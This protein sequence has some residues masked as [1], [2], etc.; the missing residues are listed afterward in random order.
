MLTRRMQLGLLGPA[1]L[2]GA[3][4]IAVLIL[5]TLLTAAAGWFGVNRMSFA[6][7]DMLFDSQSSGEA[8]YAAARQLF[9]SDREAIVL[10]HVGGN[11][12]E[13]ERARTAVSALADS[14]AEESAVGV[15]RWGF[16]RDAVSPKLIRTLPVDELREQAE[17]MAPV[18]LFLESETPAALL[19]AGM[20]EAMSRRLSGTGESA[21]AHADLEA[22]AAAF[23]GLLDTLTVRMKTPAERPVDFWSAMRDAAGEPRWNFL[24]SDGGGLLVMSVQLLEGV[25]DEAGVD[26]SLAELRRHVEAIRARFEGLEIGVTGYEASRREAEATLRGAV[27]RAAGGALAALVLLTGLAWRSVWRPAVV[28]LIP[29]AAVLWTLGGIG[30]LAGRV[31]LLALYGV[32]GAGL[33]ALFG[34]LL[35]VGAHARG[36]GRR[37]AVATAWPVVALGAVAVAVAVAGV[38]VWQ[39]VVG[40]GVHAGPSMPGLAGVREAGWAVI[41]G[42]CAAFLAVCV[43]GPALLAH[44]KPQKRPPGGA[45]GELALGLAAAAAR[46]PGRAW[47]AVGVL[48]MVLVCFAWRTPTALDLSGWM[49]ERSEARV[50]QLRAQV[51]GGEGGPVLW[52]VAEGWE[53]AVALTDRL[54]ALPEVGRVAGMGR[55]IPAEREAKAAVM[56]ELDERI[57]DAARAVAGLD[58]D[59]TS[60]TLAGQAPG[61]ELIEQV[62]FVR[63]ALMLIPGEA[64]TPTHR[65][66]TGM[67][68]SADRL[69]ADAD[70]LDPA[71]RDARLTA[72]RDDYRVARRRAGR[73]LVELLDPS[74]ITPSDGVGTEGLFEPWIARRHSADPNPTPRYLLEVYPAVASPGRHDAERLLA[75]RDAVF[76]V[77]PTAT[78]PWER[79]VMRGPVLGSLN[80]SVVGCFAIVLMVVVVLTCRHWFAWAGAAA[81]IV[82][83]AVALRAGVGWMGQPM[84]TA[85]VLVWP[86]VGMVVVMWT[87]TLATSDPA[88]PMGRLRRGAGGE[89]L[90]F[91]LAAGFIAAA[92]LRSAAAPGLTATAVSACLAAG[93]AGLV[94]LLVVPGRSVREA[95]PEAKR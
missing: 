92:G 17:R 18:R 38:G 56:A 1:H 70:E 88:T 4:R 93:I 90:G 53:Q 28:V 14:L 3:S 42:A 46:R 71:V 94:A 60:G 68:T 80:V 55:M 51:D 11:D 72:L 84:V 8:R 78:G 6:D 24:R 89:A 61:Q 32:A 59:A 39:V 43:V 83:S 49:P 15:V 30:L 5:A 81:A 41:G 22:G 40:G 9:N 16:D 29:A 31:N 52:C 67:K 27:M 47:S 62:R 82:L 26:G 77:D 79:A 64:G 37:R 87:L 66:M 35:L 10:V 34:G 33:P 7:I 95:R 20:S 58:L 44:T 69:L 65:I 54:R 12:V 2:G 36:G 63:N 48:L 76:Q 73:A 57:G 86:A 74:P 23:T 85:G 21:D 75:F 13:D 50:W 19:R 91:V 45:R 25:G